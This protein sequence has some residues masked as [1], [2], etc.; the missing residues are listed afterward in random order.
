MTSS[1]TAD[2]NPLEASC[3]KIHINNRSI[4]DLLNEVDIYKQKCYVL[5][6]IESTRA[7]MKHETKHEIKWITFKPV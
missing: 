6:Y 1:N 2:T 5:K 7:N 4:E 3:Y